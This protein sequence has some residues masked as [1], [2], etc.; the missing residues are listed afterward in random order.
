MAYPRLTI[1]GHFTHEEI[2]RRYRSCKDPVEK[3]RWQVLWLMTDPD[4][5]RSADEAAALVGFSGRMSLLATRTR[6][7]PRNP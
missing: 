4:R 7:S 3:T 2:G 5:L 6:T 1:V